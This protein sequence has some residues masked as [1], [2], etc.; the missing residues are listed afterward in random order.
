MYFRLFWSR[1]PALTAAL[2]QVVGQGDRYIAKPVDSDASEEE[3][4]EEATEEAEG[5]E[6]RPSPATHAILTVLKAGAC[7]RQFW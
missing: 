1:K 4:E 7:G 2:F 5:S 3:D 6:A